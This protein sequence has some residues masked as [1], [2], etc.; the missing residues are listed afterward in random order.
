MPAEV[1]LEA[2]DL[3]ARR[4][5]GGRGALVLDGVSVTV[6]AGEV[7]DIGG[8]SGVG[9]ST[10]LLAL[11]RLLPGATGELVLQGTRAEDVDPRAWRRD[12]LYVPQTPSAP[13][14]TVAD[15]LGTPWRLH[16][17][18]GETP[19]SPGAMRSALEALGLGDLALDRE[20]DRLSVGQAQRLALA[21]ALLSEPAVLLLDEPDANLDDDAARLAYDAV[22]AFAAAGHGVLRV[23][24]RR[25]AEVADRH[26]RLADGCLREVH[27]AS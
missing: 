18:E 9:K 14:G 10:L 22:R 12:V 7:V 26:L 6:G 17:R 19:P 25:G 2:R 8:P 20:A 16:V 15:A 4:E 1:L 5:A 11:A 23:R 24:H 21:R 27:D 3:R 13:A